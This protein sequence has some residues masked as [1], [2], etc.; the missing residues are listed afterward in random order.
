M[1]FGR[2]HKNSSKQALNVED[3]AAQQAAASQTSNNNHSGSASPQAPTQNYPPNINEN[4]LRS[5]PQHYSQAQ[6][7]QQYIRQ[8]QSQPYPAQNDLPDSDRRQYQTSDKPSLSRSQSTR[9]S[10]GSAHQQQQQQQL[11]QQ[12]SSGSVD[13]LAHEPRKDNKKEQPL[14]PAPPAERNKKGTLRSLFSSKESKS[15]PPQAHHNHT[16]SLGRRYSKRAENPPSIR[17]PQPPPPPASEQQRFEY[18]TAQGSRTHLTPQREDAENDF[19]PYE[20]KPG[21]EDVHTAPPS[22]I[23]EHHPSHGIRPVQS[24]SDQED[25]DEE[26]RGPAPPPH[27]HPLVQQQHSDASSLNNYQYQQHQQGHSQQN[28]HPGD[29]ITTD[30]YRQ[31]NPETVSQLSYDSPT[32]DQREDQQRAYHANGNS[33][34]SYQAPRQDYTEGASPVQVTRPTSQSNNGTM[35]QSGASQPTSR[36]EPRQQPSQGGA[37]Q[38]ESR[39]GPPPNYSRQAFPGNSGQQI[40]SS[41]HP[42]LPA[43]NANYRGGPPQREAS[44]ITGGGDQGRSTPPPSATGERSVDDNYKDLRMSIV[45]F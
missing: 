9:H 3:P 24:E 19:D 44:Q 26:R 32:I 1:G 45:C 14:P 22:A 30:Q 42:S 27:A 29:I 28:L 4:D 36:R 20:I 12:Q 18:Q 17:T 23:H 38:A 39:D 34:L 21:Q 6:A 11:L 7:Y 37:G 13:N 5:T 16:S 31:P 25:Y 33:P 35:P 8:D 15:T 2:S 40:P 10:V 41:A 43:N